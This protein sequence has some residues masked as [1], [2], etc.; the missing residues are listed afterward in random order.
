MAAHPLRILD[1]SILIILPE[2]WAC[3]NENLLRK[4]RSVYTCIK[5]PGQDRRSD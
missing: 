2:Y 3:L 1:T 5:S 4:D